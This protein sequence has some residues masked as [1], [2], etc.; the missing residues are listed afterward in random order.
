MLYIYIYIPHHMCSW[1]VS[2][3]QYQTPNPVLW[4]PNNNNNNNNRRLTRLVLEFRTL[5]YLLLWGASSSS[6]MDAFVFL[7]T[8][9][10]QARTC[11]HVPTWNR[12]ALEAHKDMAPPSFSPNSTVRCCC[13]CCLMSSLSE[14]GRNL[15]QLGQPGPFNH[16]TRVMWMRFAFIERHT[17][18]RIALLAMCDWSPS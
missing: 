10:S 15:S 7:A 8:C 12:P 18:L 17:E 13:C 3:L 4:C 2:R 16:L 14:C 11:K 1:S 5:S 9:C 6:T